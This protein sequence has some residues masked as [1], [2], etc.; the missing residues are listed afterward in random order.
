MMIR[1]INLHQRCG[2]SDSPFAR[3]DT[4]LYCRVQKWVGGEWTSVGTGWHHT[5]KGSCTQEKKHF[6]VIEKYIGDVKQGSKIGPDLVESII[7]RTVLAKVE[8]RR[9]SSKLSQFR[10]KITKVKVSTFWMSAKSTDC[11]RR[12]TQQASLVSFN[13]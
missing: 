3:K 12:P 13:F 2:Y 9:I 6:F 7:R 11:R 4:F 1:L 5:Q 10:L 8:L